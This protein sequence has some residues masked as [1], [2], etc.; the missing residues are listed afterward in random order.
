MNWKLFRIFCLVLSFSIYTLVCL[1]FYGSNIN[2]NTF[3]HTICNYIDKNIYLIYII[4]LSGLTLFLFSMKIL[5]SILQFLF[6]FIQFVII[7][8]IVLSIITFS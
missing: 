5:P 7:I 3:W 4:L 2:G 6:L 8:L 1:I